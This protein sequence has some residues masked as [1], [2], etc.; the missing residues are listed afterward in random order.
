MTF[1]I[2]AINYN[3]YRWI[4]NNYKVKETG[5]DTTEKKHFAFIIL[6]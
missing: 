1:G 4:E 5:I 3:V 2:W 6:E